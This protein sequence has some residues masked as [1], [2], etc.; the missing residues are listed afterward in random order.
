MVN[1]ADSSEN[2][3][4]VEQAGGSPDGLFTT[5]ECSRAGGDSISKIALKNDETR[6]AV[7]LY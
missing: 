5:T 2:Q 7:T 3:V 1:I 6:V 4:V